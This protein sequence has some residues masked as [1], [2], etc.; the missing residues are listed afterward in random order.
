MKRNIYILRHGQTEYG[1]EKRYLG[2]TDCGLSVK[3]IND[4]K[5]LARIFME[6]GVIINNI[7]SSDL[8]RCKSTVNIAFPDREV[9]F[10]EELREINMGNLEGLTFDEVKNKDPEVYKKRGENIADFIPLNGESFRSCQQ[11][12]IKILNYIIYSTKGNVVICSHAGFIRALICSLLN[13]DLD[14]KNI[15]NIKQDYGCINIIS[16]DGS[17]FFVEGINL[18]TLSIKLSPG[19]LQ[20]IK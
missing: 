2:H 4:A 19:S 7:F 10:L 8:V 16:F 3:G 18:K 15:F 9:I 20:Y 13:L 17:D 12:A 11:R 5:Q 14:L 6:S 1:R